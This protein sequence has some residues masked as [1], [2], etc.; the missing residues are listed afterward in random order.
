MDFYKKFIKKNIRGHDTKTY[1]LFLVPIGNA[2]IKENI[3]FHP[4]DPVLDF[5]RKASNICCCWDAGSS[6]GVY[7]TKHFVV[8]PGDLL[9]DLV[10][11]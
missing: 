10:T 8:S 11:L 3:F 5:Q 9:I 4:S 7:I 1:Q 2:K 6:G